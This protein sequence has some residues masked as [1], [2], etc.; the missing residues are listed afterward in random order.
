MRRIPDLCV[1]QHIQPVVLLT[2]EDLCEWSA[3]N[4]TTF[5]RYTATAQQWRE[6]LDKDFVHAEDEN[7]NIFL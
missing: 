1:S 3:A 4:A 6:M 2:I 7:G 5:A